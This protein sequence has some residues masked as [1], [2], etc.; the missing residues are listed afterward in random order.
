MAERQ[1]D[2]DV[3]LPFRDRPGEDGR[4]GDDE[5]SPSPGST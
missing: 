5:I 2:E 4:L 3:A 1:E